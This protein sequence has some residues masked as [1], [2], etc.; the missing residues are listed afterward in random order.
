MNA[1]PP[2]A[3][4]PLRERL[5]E[6]RAESVR[7]PSENLIGDQWSSEFIRRRAAI[8]ELEALIKR[9]ENNNAPRHP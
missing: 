7:E 9:L 2:Q 5:A 1:P 4:Q 3:I 8:T 6:L